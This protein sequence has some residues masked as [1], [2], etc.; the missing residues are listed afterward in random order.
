MY[1]GDYE[2]FV[3]NREDKL[4]NQQKE[5]EAQKQYR[6]HIQVII[7]NF[8]VVENL[9]KWLIG[10][11]MIRHFPRQFCLM[12]LNW[13][14]F[15]VFIDRFRYNANRA[16]QVQSKLK[17]L[18]KLL[19][20]ILYIWLKYL[21]DLACDDQYTEYIWWWLCRPELKPVEKE[22]EVVLKFPEGDKLS[23]PNPAVRRSILSL[24]A[25]QTGFREC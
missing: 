7:W 2:L 9:F 24:C 22:S 3:R 16:S 25:R 5:Y 21:H 20:F 14:I 1:K 17:M 15:Q 6:D 18:E 12:D 19:V 23:P 4:K 8:T 11:Q 13:F 10:K